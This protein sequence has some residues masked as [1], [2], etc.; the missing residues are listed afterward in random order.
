[1]DLWSS[2]DCAA[3]AAALDRYPAVVEAQHVNGLAEVDTWYRTALPGL[4]AGREPAYATLDELQRVT[5]WKMKRGVWRER[6]RQLVAGNPPAVVEATSRA[7]FAAA[8]DPRRPIALLSDLAGVGPATASG[9]LAAYRPD[10][11]PFFDEL[12]AAQVPGLGPVAWAAPYYVRYAAAL[13]ERAAML[14]AACPDH[15]WTAQDVS[16]ALWAAAGGKAGA[17]ATG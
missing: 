7:A 6:N 4:I 8:P 9:L 10:L 1:M 11:Y 13:Y 3:W 16:Q 2:T 17:A 5:A 14:R 15:D 12:V